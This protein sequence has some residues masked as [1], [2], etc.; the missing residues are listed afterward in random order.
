MFDSVCESASSQPGPPVLQFVAFQV[1]PLADGGLQVSLA[2]TFLDEAELEF[3]GEDIET[4]RV[5]SIDEAVAAIRRRLVEA[6]QVS[7]PTEH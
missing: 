3:I 1:T 6:L 4:V 7:T 5:S 2:A